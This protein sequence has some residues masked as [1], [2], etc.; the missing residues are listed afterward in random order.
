MK[1]L[2]YFALI[3]ICGRAAFGQ[4]VNPGSSSLPSG[5]G[6]VAV[7][8]GVGA[9]ATQAQ[10]LSAAALPAPYTG[11]VSTRGNLAYA[12]NSANTWQMSR[13]AMIARAPIAANGARPV[14]VNYYVPATNVETSLGTSVTYKVSIE[15]P[16]GTIAGLCTYSSAT[17]I[18]VSG[19]V[20][21]IPDLAGCPHAAIPFGAMFWVRALVTNAAGISFTNTNTTGFYSAT[22][23]GFLFGTGTPTDDTLSGTVGTSSANYGFGPVA[24][25]GQTTQPS[26]CIVG[27]S[28]ALGI[29]DK[30]TDWTLDTG[31][32]ARSVGP[33]YNYLKMAITGS[34]VNQA[35]THFT[36]R[37]RL[38]QYCTHAYDEYG[39]NDLKILSR[40]AAQVAADRS[41]LAGL[42]AIPTFGTTLPPETTSTDSWATTTNQT[43]SQSTTAFNALAIAGI[44]GE[45]GVVDIDS[46]V[47]PLATNLWPVSLITGA[48]S[49]TAG[50]G[51]TDGIHET[52]TLNVTIQHSGIVNTAWIYR[53]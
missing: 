40:T 3:L 48:T 26:V 19:T 52:S 16:A 51:T 46:V 34:S 29:N 9:L 42:L 8:G 37:L 25:I 44:S 53:R 32:I 12:F 35:I 13:T 11:L 45:V 20:D 18:T 23:D 33:V 5:T 36:N 30:S 24:V 38:V 47:D 14:F 15:Y 7:N 27:D 39:I 22:N 6:I 43:V 49:G 10:I 2:L 21:V 17:T 50:Y 31:E 1:K 41:T 4:V 28:R